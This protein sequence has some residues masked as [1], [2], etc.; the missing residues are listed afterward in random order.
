M[1]R[2]KR[3]ML[4]QVQCYI[5]ALLVA[6]ATI[7]CSAKQNLFAAFD[8][9]LEKPLTGSKA[10]ANG[11]SIVCDSE[12]SNK[13]N[14]QS[15]QQFYHKVVPL[16]DKDYVVKDLSFITTTS[17]VWES[18]ILQLAGTSPPLYLMFKKFKIAL[19]G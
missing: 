2:L 19:I 13:V 12:I 18:Y 6:F 14:E 11:I 5:W 15:A 1:V 10:L 17:T 8:I 4:F 9:S 3:F 7:G 16:S